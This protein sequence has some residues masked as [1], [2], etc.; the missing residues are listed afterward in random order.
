MA[1]ITGS[2]KPPS[3]PSGRY[4]HTNPLRREAGLRLLTEPL[5]EALRWAIIRAWRR[6][7]RLVAPLALPEVPSAHRQ[8]PAEASLPARSAYM[9]GLIA[10]VEVEM[11][12][13]LVEAPKASMTPVTRNRLLSA[14]GAYLRSLYAAL[15][16]QVGEVAAL[17]EFQRL[18]RSVQ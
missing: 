6:P 16:A 15:A 1:L 17:A 2:P 7:N 4:V 13:R 9:L 12:Q 5:P 18:I 14:Q 3:F 10:L 11:A 8:R